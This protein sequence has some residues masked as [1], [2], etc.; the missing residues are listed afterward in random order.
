MAYTIRK[1]KNQSGFVYR[2]V[3]KDRLGKQITSKTFNR[4]TDAKIWADRIDSDRDAIAAYGNKGA[5]MT[6]SELF[7]EYI[8]QWHGKD[9]EHQFQRAMYWVNQFNA[10]HLVEVNAD[11]IRAALKLNQF[12]F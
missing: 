8:L 10:Y 9:Q 1:I 3:I 5:K 7:D 6:F 12:T 11:K 2:A 4:K